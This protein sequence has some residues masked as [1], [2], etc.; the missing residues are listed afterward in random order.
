MN[1]LYNIV[2]DIMKRKIRKMFLSLLMAII[3]GALCGRLVYSIYDKKID[4]DINGKKLYLVQSGAY[5]SYDNM[6]NTNNI[7]NY[8]YFKDS[9]GLYKSIVGITSDSANIEKVKN[10][11]EGKVAVLEYYS[12]N[13]ELNDKIGEY[14]SKIKN[15]ED[16]NEVKNVVRDMLALY[17]DKDT[18][19]VQLKS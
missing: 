3:S 15:V 17:K 13:K 6:V 8:V 5:S 9:D 1:N 11:Y 14:D 7:S 10:T 2:G 19:L 18:K 4:E 16:A 12:S